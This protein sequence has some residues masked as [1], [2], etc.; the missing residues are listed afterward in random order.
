MAA[1]FVRVLTYREAKRR[2]VMTWVACAQNSTG[3]M[4]I[5]AGRIPK[6]HEIEGVNKAAQT[7]GYY[8][9]IEGQAR[10]L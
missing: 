3:A 5:V 9:V 4:H 8:K 10:P 6:G 2:P 7:A 1:Y